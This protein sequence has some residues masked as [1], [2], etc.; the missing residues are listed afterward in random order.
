M[1]ATNGHNNNDF[2][3]IAHSPARLD[4]VIRE[5]VNTYYYV[6]KFQIP[7]MG[8]PLWFK[9]EGYV[10]ELSLSQR[11]TNPNAVYS[12][13]RYLFKKRVAHAY[14]THFFKKPDTEDIEFIS[15][16]EVKKDA[17]VKIRTRLYNY[18][19]NSKLYIWS[20]LRYLFKA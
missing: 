11:Y 5:M 4:T 13:E 12:I 19:H 8:R 18:I 9:V 7:L 6:K 1:F 16:V 20:K 2:L 3:L 15:W 17:P 14:D 10:D